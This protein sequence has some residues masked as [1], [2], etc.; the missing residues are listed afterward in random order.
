M[1][2]YH[3]SIGEVEPDLFSHAIQ[4]G[5]TLKYGKPINWSHSAILVEDADE[6]SG[7]YD[8]TERG[9]AKGTLEHALDEGRSV[10][11]IQTLLKI[12]NEYKALGWLQGF[13]GTEYSLIGFAVFLPQWCRSLAQFLLP[14][15][16]IK[17]FANGRA[18]SFCSESTAWFMRDNCPGALQDLLLSELNCDRVD[19]VL[20]A[21]IANTY[22]EELAPN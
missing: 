2:F 16:V 9:F 22:R 7:L 11:R 5:L 18:G 21:Q 10:I 3:L 12:K 15:F 13:I 1:K 14:A 4:E 8:S 19:P 6:D 17:K 20:A